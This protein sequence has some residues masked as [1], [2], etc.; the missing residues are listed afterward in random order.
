MIMSQADVINYQQ[1]Y[2]IYTEVFPQLTS[3]VNTSPGDLS[4]VLL[5]SLSSLF[6]PE[7]YKFGVNESLAL[8]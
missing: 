4:I 8:K 1:N 6:L 5:V 3:H 7:L 2:S